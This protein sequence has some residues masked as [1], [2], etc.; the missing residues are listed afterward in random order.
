M[1]VLAKKW[2]IDISFKSIF[3]FE[4]FVHIHFLITDFN[5]RTYCSCQDYATSVFACSA[6]TSEGEVGSSCSRG[7]VYVAG[8]SRILVD[9]VW[10]FLI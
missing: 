8:W 4:W 3:F 10:N 6:G 2:R 7:A 9:L 5:Y 1:H